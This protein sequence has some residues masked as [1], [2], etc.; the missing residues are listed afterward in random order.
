MVC[1]V[2]K[3]LI[4]PRMTSCYR[5]DHTGSIVL[6]HV[7]CYPRAPTPRDNGPGSGLPR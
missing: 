2:C 6:V 5:E 3:N 4:T 7:Y 1:P